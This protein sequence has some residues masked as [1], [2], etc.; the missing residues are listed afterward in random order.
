MARPLITT[1]ISS[2]MYFWVKLLRAGGEPGVVTRSNAA[3]NTASTFPVSRRGRSPAHVHT[4]RAR[5]STLM[6]STSPARASGSRRYKCFENRRKRLD[7]GGEQDRPHALPVGTSCERRCSL[8]AEFRL[9]SH[10]ARWRPTTV[11]PVPGEPPH[12]GRLP[13][14][15]SGNQSPLGANLIRRGCDLRRHQLPSAGLV[16][17][18]LAE[19]PSPVITGPPCLWPCRCINDVSNAYGIYSL[20]GER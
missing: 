20:W 16:R 9:A 10:T 7:E 15:V 2:R 8:R 11:L 4:R 5:L 14:P 18:L 3:E 17:L 6:N 12:P 1:L 13:R 19:L